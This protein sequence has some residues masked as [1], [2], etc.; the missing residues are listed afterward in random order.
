M[1]TTAVVDDS[2]V[3][4][5]TVYTRHPVRQVKLIHVTAKQ[6]VYTYSFTFTSSSSSAISIQEATTVLSTLKDFVC[7]RVYY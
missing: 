5:I 4:V 7:I 1:A 2:L 6:V 3:F